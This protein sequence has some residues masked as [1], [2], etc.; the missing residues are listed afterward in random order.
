M[1]RKA[2]LLLSTTHEI[3]GRGCIPTNGSFLLNYKYF[4]DATQRKNHFQFSL[5]RQGSVFSI[6]SNGMPNR[7]TDFTSSYPH[8]QKKIGVQ[9][10]ATMSKQ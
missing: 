8:T 7:N 1:Q 5:A 3:Q 2:Y 10:N 6:F 4:D 9:A